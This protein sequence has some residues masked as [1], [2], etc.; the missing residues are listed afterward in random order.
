MATSS[1]RKPLTSRPL[2]LFYVIFF[3]IHLLASS[4]IDSQVF[5]PTRCIPSPLRAVLDNFLLDTNDPLMRS[6][7]TGRSDQTWFMAALVAEMVIQLPI[8]A[9]GIWA[10]I[11][12]EFISA[13]FT[14][15]GFFL[16]AGL[17]WCMSR[18]FSSPDDKRI[19]PALIL[20]ASVGAC[21][22]TQSA[23]PPPSL[24]K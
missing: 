7:L 13:L 20:Y 3:A 23:N 4:L 21:S 8:F 19:Y 17:T 12:G 22:K 1:L 16:G 14:E 2:D 5:L 6:A 9:L 10:L 15:L 24:T 11:K 18:L